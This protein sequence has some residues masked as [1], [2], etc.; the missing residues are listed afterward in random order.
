[1]AKFCFFWLTDVHSPGSTPRQGENEWDTIRDL[2][3][4]WSSPAIRRAGFNKRNTVVIDAEARKVRGCKK[5]AIVVREYV[6]AD[7][8]KTM[9][10]ENILKALGDYLDGTVFAKMQKPGADVREVLAS[11]PCPL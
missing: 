6:A 5:N 11:N 7:V 3:K 10:E 9:T 1:L 4:I 2:S 8:P